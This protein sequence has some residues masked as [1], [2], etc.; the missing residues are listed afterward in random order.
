MN[1]P[2]DDRP[3]ATHNGFYIGDEVELPDGRRGCIDEIVHKVVHADVGAT[4][5]VV[6]LD[7]ELWLDGWLTRVG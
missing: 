1:I 6:R 4:Y 7:D 5:S 2:Q 3:Y